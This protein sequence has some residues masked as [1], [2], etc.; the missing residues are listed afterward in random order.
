MNFSIRAIIR[1]WWAPSHR[2][3]CPGAYWQS[4]VGEL[5]RRGGRVHEAGAFLLG[6]ERAEKREV[7]SAIFYDELDPQ[8]Y[9]TGVCILHGDAFAKLWALCRARKLTVVADVH[10]HPGAGF[11]SLSDKTNPM[12]ARAG[13]IAIILPNFARWPI[14]RR[15]L[16]IFE[17]RGEHEWTNRSPSHAPDFFYTGFWS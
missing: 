5:D 17:Y 1:E 8:A 3:S 2:V 10:T 14:D 16:G 9:E 15:Q 6:I 11:Q 12:V 4:V 7:Q 13:H